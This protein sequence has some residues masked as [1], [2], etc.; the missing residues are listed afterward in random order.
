MDKLFWWKVSN[1]QAC[2]QLNAATSVSSQSLNVDCLCDIL[3][4]IQRGQCLPDAYFA[5]EK[6]QK[7]RMAKRTLKIAIPRSGS[8]SAFDFTGVT[9]KFV[10]TN[11]IYVD[12]QNKKR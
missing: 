9:T 11:M 1:P 6:I 2:K 3:K 10:I 7:T 12:S 5:A 8:F 4:L